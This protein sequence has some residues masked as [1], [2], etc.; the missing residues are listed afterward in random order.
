MT[1]IAVT[2]N[3]AILVRF[4]PLVASQTDDPFP[5]RR[6]PVA[7]GQSFVRP[8]L[9][10]IKFPPVCFDSSKRRSFRQLDE[11]G[12]KEDIST[13]VRGGEMPK[14]RAVVAGMGNELRAW[15]EPSGRNRDTEEAQMNIIH[16]AHVFLE[17][18]AGAL[19]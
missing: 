8:H 4:P 15:V 16:D 10:E 2:A 14:T 7:R 9:A 5:S 13:H 12:R 18:G 19:A 1:L 11:R 17:F 6:H 3:I